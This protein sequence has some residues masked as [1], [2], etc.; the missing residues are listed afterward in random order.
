MITERVRERNYKNRISSGFW[1][2][3]TTKYNPVLYNPGRK[4]HMR[5]DAN[6]YGLPVVTMENC[7]NFDFST[8]Y[9]K[10][11]FFKKVVMANFA[12]K[13]LKKRI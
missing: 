7:K 4:L 1:F 11:E 5:R 12:E 2:S 10:L 8:D 13:V 3:D 9:G 6:F